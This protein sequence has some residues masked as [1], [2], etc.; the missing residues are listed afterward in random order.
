MR[1]SSAGSQVIRKQSLAV[2]PV[3]KL[4]G[5][6]LPPPVTSTKS[7]FSLRLTSDFAVSAH[8][9]KVYYE[10]HELIVLL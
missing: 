1:P 5:F 10:G 3:L 6:H 8:G 9:F 2:L 7:V 4:T